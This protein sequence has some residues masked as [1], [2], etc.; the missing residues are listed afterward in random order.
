MCVKLVRSIP[1][2]GSLTRLGI[3]GLGGLQTRPTGLSSSGSQPA[4]AKDQR[5]ND[6]RNG[7]PREDCV[8]GRETDDEEYHSNDKEGT[9][10]LPFVLFHEVMSF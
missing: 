6:K 7:H 1:K 4:T 5:D 8:V 10:C 3:F 2:G 9:G